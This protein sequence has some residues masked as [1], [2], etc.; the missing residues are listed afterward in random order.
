MR[1]DATLIMAAIDV[2]GM[3]REEARDPRGANKERMLAAAGALQN[4]TEYAINA[5]CEDAYGSAEED[6]PR[7]IP[8]TIGAFAAASRN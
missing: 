5:I 8:T 2:I 3:L 4:A 1:A 6:E 7:Y